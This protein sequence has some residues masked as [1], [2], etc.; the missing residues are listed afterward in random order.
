VILDGLIGGINPSTLPQ[1]LSV[2]PA[3]LSPGHP[4]RQKV[5]QQRPISARPKHSLRLRAPGCLSI[6]L[7]DQQK[8]KPSPKLLEQNRVDTSAQNRADPNMIQLAQNE[9]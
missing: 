3:K 4:L 1:L 9:P 5:P 6:S 2:S 7:T 8:G